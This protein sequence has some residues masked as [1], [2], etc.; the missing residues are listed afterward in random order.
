MEIRN[1]YLMWIGK[2]HYK[3]IADWTDE[4]LA[5]GISKRLP[6]AHVAAK[7]MEPGTV[8]FV[9]HDEGEYKECHGCLG[10]IE[11]PERRKLQ[12][13]RRRVESESKALCVERDGDRARY[14]DGIITK[15]ELEKAE[16]RIEKLDAARAEKAKKISQ[17][18]IDLP[19]WIKAGTG[20]TA[21]LMFGEGSHSTQ[22]WDYRRYNYWLHQPKSFNA[23]DVIEKSM[24]EVCGGTGRLPEGKVFGMFVP[25]AFEYIVPEGS[26]GVIT[27][28][29]VEMGISAIG[30]GA[31][32][33]EA[34]RKC[35]YRKPGG[36]YAVTDAAGDDAMTKKAVEVLVAEGKLDLAG[37]EVNGQFAHF[38]APVPIEAKRF[39]GIKRWSLDPAVED[40]AE[41]IAEA[42][43]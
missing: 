21:T 31:V 42:V 11:N 27:A 20:G 41:M 37:V 18:I 28:K 4:A 2:E 33:K 15:E 38:L 16:A 8:V 3:T 39:R 40:E 24:C 34:K 13:D 19:E 10:T 25:G 35:G 7:M 6:N 22:T 9:A 32:K 5:Q 14:A 30:A 1:T 29:M 36:V 12:S 23:D 43:A 26:D 17:A